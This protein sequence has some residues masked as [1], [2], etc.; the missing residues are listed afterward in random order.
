MTVYQIERKGKYFQW[1]NGLAY[2]FHGIADSLTNIKKRKILSMEKQSSLLFNNADH[3]LPNRKN[4][5][6][7]FEGTNDLTYFFMALLK[8]KLHRFSFSKEEK[9]TLYKEGKINFKGETV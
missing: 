3:T 5:K 4:R 7:K 1:S 6:N 2:I 9:T 8:S